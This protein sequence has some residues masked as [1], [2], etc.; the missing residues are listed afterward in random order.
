MYRFFDYGSYHKQMMSNL[1]G[2]SE[3]SYFAL[4]YIPEKE[5]TDL[6]KVIQN[7]A[8]YFQTVMKTYDCAVVDLLSIISSKIGLHF[9]QLLWPLPMLKSPTQEFAKSLIL[10]LAKC[11][12]LIQSVLKEA[13]G[14]LFNIT[15]FRHLNSV[16]LILTAILTNYSYLASKL[17]ND[18]DKLLDSIWVIL[19]KKVKPSDNISYEFLH[20]F[21]ELF[22]MLSKIKTPSSTNPLQ[23]VDTFSFRSIYMAQRVISLAERVP[24]MAKV[25]YCSFDE[26]QC[27]QNSK[28]W[29]LK[30]H[31]LV[32]AKLSEFPL[33][34]FSN[35]IEISSNILN[36]YKKEAEKI[37]RNAFLHIKSPLLYARFLKIFLEFAKALPKGV[38][39]DSM[40][41]HDQIYTEMVRQIVTSGKLQLRGN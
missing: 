33:L 11:T 2:I 32:Y 23:L 24:E 13:N 4:S 35:D 41:P 36:T 10:I 7:L 31:D 20:N 34:I 8:V 16:F 29:N 15:Q 28:A 25:S 27:V 21:V 6:R 17:K 5:K 9:S 19:L 26:C 40:I 1:I 30:A 14:V 39:G 37:Y 22:L 38:R 18:L 3:N 12:K